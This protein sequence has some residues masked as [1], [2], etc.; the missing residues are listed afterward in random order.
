MKR[1]R[2]DKIVNIYPLEA[3]RVCPAIN[4]V[5]AELIRLGRLVDWPPNTAVPEGA[6]NLARLCASHRKAALQT[7]AFQWGWM[8]GSIMLMD[9]LQPLVT[10]KSTINPLNIRWYLKHRRSLLKSPE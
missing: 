7:T 9:N 5:V 2:T 8:R 1:Q 3:A 10:L 6:T 4:P